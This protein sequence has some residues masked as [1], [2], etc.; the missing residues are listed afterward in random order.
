MG[1][2]AIAAA[3]GVVVAGILLAAMYLGIQLPPALLMSVAAALSVGAAT[4]VLTRYA[5]DRPKERPRGSELLGK[6]IRDV[7]DLVTGFPKGGG[8]VQ[9]VI[10]ADTIVDELEVVK[11]PASYADRDI[12]V[13]FKDNGK[14]SSNPGAV[15]N[16]VTLK[17]LF[18]ALKGQPNFLHVLLLN[19]HDEFVGYIP[20]FRAKT[21]FTGPNGEGQIVKYIIEILADHDEKSDEDG[22]SYAKSVIL[23]EIDGLAKTDVINDEV[24]VEDAQRRMQ[25]GFHRLMVLHGGRHRKPT[26]LLFSERLLEV[27]NAN[28]S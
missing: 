8:A 16:P 13:K 26:G 11:N 18:S 3:A 23:R 17:R 28:R 19:S 1:K 25:G 10:K 24:K 2:V 9:L 27:T 12:V 7:K 5:L 20:G 6:R 14:P 4:A 22:T 21:Q 15:F